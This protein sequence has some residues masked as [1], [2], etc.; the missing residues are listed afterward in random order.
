MQ[1]PISSPARSLHKS[2][3]LPRS[4]ASVAHWLFDQPHLPFQINAPL[5]S[6]IA[7][8]GSLT[9]HI[10]DIWTDFGQDFDPLSVDQG[11]P[12]DGSPT[13][14]EGSLESDSTSSILAD[15]KSPSTVMDLNMILTPAMRAT[16]DVLAG[17]AFC[18]GPSFNPNWSPSTAGF[19]RG[20][21]N[22]TGRFAFDMDNDHII[23]VFHG[24]S[25]K[26]TAIIDVTSN[27]LSRNRFIY[28]VPYI[29]YG[30]DDLPS[31]VLSFMSSSELRS[32]MDK[33]CV[34][35]FYKA[36]SQHQTSTNNSELSSESKGTSAAENFRSRNCRDNLTA[37]LNQ[38][39]VS[40]SRAYLKDIEALVSDL[41]FISPAW[42]GSY[43]GRKVMRCTP[44]LPQLNI[45]PSQCLGNVTSQYFI[46]FQDGRREMIS[47]AW[48]RY[49]V[50]AFG[51]R[52]HLR[53][54]RLLE[55]DNGQS[56]RS[57]NKSIAS[58]SPNRNYS[59]SLSSKR[60]HGRISKPRWLTNDCSSVTSGKSYQAQNSSHR[61]SGSGG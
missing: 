3:R 56:Y 25:P 14:S 34:R 28:A 31:Q 43:N 17:Y 38:E 26:V 44:N 5:L 59:S 30:P 29:E 46:P 2:L 23:L 53:E 36:S 16:P 24:V 20:R 35:P 42:E 39:K 51:M 61:T 52:S 12:N 21:T 58:R 32:P 37:V 33:L 50:H 60:S 18:N 9:V 6:A 22:F 57:D 8:S 49:S 11:G 41:D 1:P 40:G 10:R 47:D 55:A 7:F 45:R 54:V 4:S 19:F 48:R 13:A 15:L 27:G